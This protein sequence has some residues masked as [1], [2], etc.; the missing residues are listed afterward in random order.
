[1]SS[2]K[3]KGEAIVSKRG[4][5]NKTKTETTNNG[6]AFNWLKECILKI[7]TEVLLTVAHDQALKTMHHQT[8]ILKIN[9]DTECRMC[10]GT[11]ETVSHI[12]NMY[13]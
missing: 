12:M 11:N 3:R 9:Q 8:Q 10:K 4:K 13:Q 2:G 6:K 1:M 7:E 5:V